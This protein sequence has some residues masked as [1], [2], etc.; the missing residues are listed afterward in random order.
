M[1]S[2]LP[3][4]RCHVLDTGYCL[5]SEHLLLRGGSHQPI[6]CHALVA[7]LEHPH[8]GWLLWDTGYA[9]RM[10]DATQSWP[11]WL[12]RHATPLR[13]QPELAVVRQI[14]RFGLA[15]DDI[16]MVII[17]HF[18]ADHVAGLRDF[19]RARLVAWREAYA[20]VAT[21]RGLAA[22]RRAYVPALMPDDFLQR[23]LLLDHANGPL[24]PAL[25]PTH[26]LFADRSLLLVSLPGHARGQIGLLANTDRGRILFAADGAWMQRA[27]RE[28]RPP[29]W[30]TNVFVDDAKAARTTLARLRAFSAACPEVALVPTH[31]P[32]AYEQY[33]MQ[34]SEFGIQGSEAT[35]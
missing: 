7:L 1:S 9:P 18:H 35:S 32:E 6:E 24:L 34:G 33:V 17:S 23:A 5:A 28:Q 13:L 15:P 27:V 14:E 31:C 19:P 3:T 4:I 22:L 16:H 8:H 21:R 30:L 10:L 26:D 2:T 11:F 25:G 12:Y 20:A 29:H